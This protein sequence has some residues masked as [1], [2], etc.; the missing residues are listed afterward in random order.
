MDGERE[1]FDPPPKGM[2]ME[3]MHDWFNAMDEY[4]FKHMDPEKGMFIFSQ[5]PQLYFAANLFAVVHVLAV[6][7]EY[8]RNGLGAKL[9]AASLEHADKQGVSAYFQA[10][11]KGESLYP[12]LGWR[13]LED[14]CRFDTSEGVQTWKC[15][16]RD[17]RWKSK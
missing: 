1:D 9:L 16:M 7:P 2:N 6:L 4:H 17:A 13:D 12:R 10:S 5:F 14:D 3:L 8:Q 11:S 15:M